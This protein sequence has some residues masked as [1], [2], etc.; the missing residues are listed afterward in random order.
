M[1]NNDPNAPAGGGGRPGQQPWPNQGAVPQQY[2]QPQYAQQ[3]QAQQYAQQGGWPPASTQGSGDDSSKL[4]IIATI[5]ALV[6]ALAAIVYGAFAAIMRRD[7]FA[8]N[9]GSSSESEL[10]NSD[11]LDQYMMYGAL[12]LVVIAVLLWLFC[13]ASARRGRTG[14]GYSGFG[15]LVVGAIGAGV[16]AYLTTNDDADKI[17]TGYIV[18][19]AGFVLMGVGLLLG[20]VALRQPGEVPSGGDSGD[21]STLR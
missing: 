18:V 10:E 17:A 16:G 2:G 12:A 19:G 14:L 21:Y 15:V 20:A 1:Q 4:G 7:M 5:V 13:T 8:N 9:L 11:K 6:A 3:A